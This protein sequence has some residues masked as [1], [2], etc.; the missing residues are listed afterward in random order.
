MVIRGLALADEVV[1]PETA[2]ELGCYM[3]WQCITLRHRQKG[4][5]ITLQSALTFLC[6][7]K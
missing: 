1:V 3:L 2:A 4:T 5:A 6:F 7:G